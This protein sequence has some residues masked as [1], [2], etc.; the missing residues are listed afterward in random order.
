MSGTN[1]KAQMTAFLCW[2]RPGLF[3]E[4]K[5]QIMWFR[6][7][8]PVHSGTAP[9]VYLRLRRN[10]S[11]LIS[12]SLPLPWDVFASQNEDRALEDCG[13]QK[14]QTMAKKPRFSSHLENKKQLG[15][16]IK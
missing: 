11:T 7:T 4:K 1:H 5:W 2:A 13:R 3:F 10:R 6:S 14:L 8:G 9:Q 15:P 12:D 16:N